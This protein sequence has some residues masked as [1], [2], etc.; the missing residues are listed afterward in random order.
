MTCYLKVSNS[1]KEWVVVVGVHQKRWQGF[2]G[3]GPVPVR[4]AYHRALLLQS[5]LKLHDQQTVPVGEGG[6]AVSAARDFVVPF[7]RT[8]ARRTVEAGD[9]LEAVG[10]LVVLQFGKGVAEVADLLQA[11]LRHLV[12]GQFVAVGLF[13]LLSVILMALLGICTGGK[14]VNGPKAY[15]RRLGDV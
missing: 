12:A 8:L 9:G 4:H 2:D 3:A 11:E 1:R 14:Q 15:S 13:R 10:A 5:T 6:H 7:L